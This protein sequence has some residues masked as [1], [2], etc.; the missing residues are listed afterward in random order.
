MLTTGHWVEP[1]E[2]DSDLEVRRPAHHLV[3]EVDLPDGVRCA[4][5]RATAHGRYEAFVNG[6]RIGDQELLPGFTAYRKRLQVHSFDVAGLIHPGRNAIGFL[7]SDGWWRGQHDAS[8]IK[9]AF[10]NRVAVL[11][12]L[13][14]ELESGEV[15]VLG[16]DV[17]WRSTTSHI[18]AADGIAGEVHDLR[19][20][21]AGWAEPGTDR[22]GWNPVVVADHPKDILIPAEGPPVR[23]VEEL[24]ALS[25]R[26]LSPGRHVV[27]FGQNS[28]GWV[29]LKDLGPAGTT[30]TL[31]HGELLDD[32][33]D[34]SRANLTGAA[35]ARDDIAFQTDDVTS[36]GDGSVFEP[37]HSTK[38]FR[39]LRV[40]GHPGPLDASSVA[41]IVVHSQ[42]RRTGD[43]SCSDERLN[44]LHTAADWSFRGNVC[45]IPTDCP[46]RERAGWTGDFSSFITTAAYLYDVHDFA[47][48]WL[49]DLAAEQWE[50]GTVLNIVPDAHDLTLE[51]H[52]R[53]RSAQGAAGWGDAACH[54]PWELYRAYGRPD[55]LE[56]QYGSMRRWVDRVAACA[57]TGRHPSRAAARRDPLPHERYLWDTG[58]HFGEWTEPGAPEG[59]ELMQYLFTTDHGP[60]ATAFFHRSAVELSQAA[61][62]LGDSSASAE[63][64]ELARNVRA[65]WCAEFVDQDGHVRPQRQAELVRALAFGLLPDE[66]RP[67]AAQDLVA[68]IRAADTHL[69]TGF[70]ATPF[71]LPV[72]ADTGHLDV[73]YELLLQDTAPSWLHMIDRGATTIWEDWDGTAS[74]NHYSK[75]AVV[76]F[77]H[78]YV[79]GLQLLAPGYERFRVAP[80]P[81]G[82]LSSARTS[83]G[84]ARG[85]IEVAWRID[86]S[87]GWLLVT[88]PDGAMAE[89]LLPDG[90]TEQIEAGT[91][92]RTWSSL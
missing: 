47:A 38:G 29:R 67:L 32:A 91:Y 85:R 57:A 56:A 89:L 75:G 28:N 62:V 14:V 21:V 15:I 45:D 13:H 5:L 36:A 87:D 2:A 43:F 66:L 64:A 19:K 41:S 9:N 77:L 72:L 40:E 81:G 33:G 11:A 31:V 7:L 4:E 30:L 3:G 92:E 17:S 25:V 35:G 26:E 60:V 16:T 61:A 84:T 44:R 74:L 79:A 55:V 80:R 20:R 1:V 59:A 53:W 24:A 50:D 65:A 42:L 70:L 73:A 6:S 52:A 68:L 76:S 90:T 37:R 39:Y 54:V 69:G 27:D 48:R 46:Q 8:R 58:F 83:L 71:L 12:E 51:E 86:S 78:Q 63:Y 88:V 34:V 82:G 22:S 10:G 18:T 23:R 49:R